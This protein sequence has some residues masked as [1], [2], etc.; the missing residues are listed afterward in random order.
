MIL[1]IGKARTNKGMFDSVQYRRNPTFLKKKSDG[2][3]TTVTKELLH[4]PIMALDE[5]VYTRK[6]IFAPDPLWLGIWSLVSTKLLERN[7]LRDEKTDS[8][9]DTTNPSSNQAPYD[10]HCEAIFHGVSGSDCFFKEQQTVQ[11]AITADSSGRPEHKTR[12]NHQYVLV[13]R[14]LFLEVKAFRKK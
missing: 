12:C 11:E 5:T 10:R 6:R 2:Q 13:G 4:L 14:Y 3:P 1:S 8:N 9:T 7:K